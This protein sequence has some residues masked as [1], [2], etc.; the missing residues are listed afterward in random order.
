MKMKVRL[1]YLTVLL[2]FLGIL[3]TMIIE[4]NFNLTALAAMTA[5]SL[6]RRIHN[7]RRTDNDPFVHV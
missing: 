1:T 5:I 6:I 2:V 7:F 3:T 4:Q